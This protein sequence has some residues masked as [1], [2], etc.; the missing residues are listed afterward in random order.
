MKQNIS[1]DSKATCPRNSLPVQLSKLFP[2]SKEVISLWRSNNTECAMI[3]YGF[4]LTRMCVSWIC[5]AVLMD[6]EWVEWDPMSCES[7]ATELSHD[8]HALSLAGSEVAE[9]RLEIGEKIQSQWY[10]PLTTVAFF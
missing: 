8:T 10:L 6:F 4:R 5:D 7:K 2:W 9:K 3:D 1:L